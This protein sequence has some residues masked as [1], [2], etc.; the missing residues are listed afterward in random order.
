MAHVAADPRGVA[1]LAEAVA[2]ALPKTA[3]AGGAERDALKASAD[4]VRAA[5][6]DLGHDFTEL[7]RAALEG[8]AARHGDDAAAVGG[9]VER[10]VTVRSDV[11]AHFFDDTVPSL[12]A[13]RAEGFVVG[14]VTNG[15]CDVRRHA[16]VSRLFDFEC[17]AGSAGASKPHPAP[18]WQ[19]C[20][21]AGAALP[22]AEPTR[23]AARPC[24]MVH[25]GDEVRS[26]LIGALGA[27]FRAVLITRD[28]RERS[29]EERSALP[30]PDADRWREVRTL[31]EAVAVVREWNRP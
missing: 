3:A 6:P 23:A 14:A 27:G 7:R 16:A 22:G 21:G 31:E 20:A 13:L 29:E 28:G 25:V 4:A 2:A 5:Q 12:E 10:F 8:E 26:D 9:V 19:A 17:S 15:N 1:A 11:A 18:F 24:E 30:P